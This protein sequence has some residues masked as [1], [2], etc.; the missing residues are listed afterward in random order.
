M[1]SILD[2]W[3]ENNEKSGFW[4]KSH[5]NKTKFKVIQVLKNKK[6][7]IVMSRGTGFNFF[8]KYYTVYVINNERWEIVWKQDL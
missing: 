3:K 4:I 6:L 5:T 7:A 1:K 8:K 2:I